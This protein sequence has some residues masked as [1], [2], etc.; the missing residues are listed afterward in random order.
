MFGY[1]T[2]CRGLRSLFTASLIGGLWVGSFAQAAPAEQDAHCDEMDSTSVSSPDGRWVAR[3]YGEV[4]DLGL[5]SSAS[6]VVELIRAGSVTLR[7]VVLGM[8]MPPNKT[9]WP[10]LA[11]GSSDKV[12]IDLP[13]NAQIGVQVANFQGVEVSVRFCPRDPTVRTQWLEY[14]ASY[15]QWIADTSAWTQTKRRNPASTVP[16]PTR[17]KPPSTGV[18]ATC[19]E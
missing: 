8:T 6:V 10:K 5:S 2:A 9:A 13:S 18:T 11:W 14:R 17:P 15:R 4:C 3:S 19:S 16:E 1:Y 7:Q 12:L